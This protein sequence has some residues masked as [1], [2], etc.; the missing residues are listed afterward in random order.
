MAAESAAWSAR[1]ARAA[2]WEKER[3]WMLEILK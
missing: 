3:D 1:A 2:A